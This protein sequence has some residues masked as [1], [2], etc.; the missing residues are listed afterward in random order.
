MALALCLAAPRARAQDLARPWLD[1]RTIETRRFSFYYAPGLEAWTRAVA[2]RMEAVDSAVAA[3]VGFAPGARVRVVVDNPFSVSNGSA[4]PFID[5]PVLTFWAA[6]PSPR[7]EIGNWRSWGE[8]LAVHEFAHL[9]HLARPS[10]NP[11][12]RMLW[13]WAPA[14]V[15]PLVLNAPRWAIEGYA[16]FVEGR[17]T[18][19]GRPNHAWRAAVLRQWALEGQLPT[20]DQLDA[21]SAFDG[22]SFAYLA[23]SAYLEWLAQRGGDSSLV[24]VWRRA[25]ARVP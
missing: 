7:E 20:Y 12:Q 13:E 21:W 24:H 6:P 16:T 2:S 14:D 23:G 18:G 22:G 8:M 5:A 10:R 4:L 9:A 3:L 25:T 11:L 17:I 15:G 1:W 19:T